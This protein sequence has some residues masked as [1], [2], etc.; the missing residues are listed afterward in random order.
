MDPRFEIPR[1]FQYARRG[2]SGEYHREGIWRQK[3]GYAVPKAG[4]KS[5]RRA[6]SHANAITCGILGLTAYRWRKYFES[7]SR[8]AQLTAALLLLIAL[9]CACASCHRDTPLFTAFRVE[10]AVAAIGM[11]LAMAAGVLSARHA[12]RSQIL[13]VIMR[14]PALA[15]CSRPTVVLLC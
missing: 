8:R 6:P 15:A 2:R 11:V 1:R 3:S 12:R 7:M 4:E 5:F 14:P 9:A 10:Q 13:A